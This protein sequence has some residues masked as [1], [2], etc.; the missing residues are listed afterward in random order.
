MD[1][2][3]V[4]QFHRAWPNKNIY[5]VQKLEKPNDQY[6]LKTNKCIRTNPCIEDKHT[7]TSTISKINQ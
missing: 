7:F 5:F 2:K 3:K 6:F 4:S 1:S